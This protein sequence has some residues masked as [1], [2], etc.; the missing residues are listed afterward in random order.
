MIAMYEIHFHCKNKYIKTS[1]KIRII[2]EDE[3][4]DL[5]EKEEGHLRPL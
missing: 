5:G 4:V 3:N 1:M 2:G